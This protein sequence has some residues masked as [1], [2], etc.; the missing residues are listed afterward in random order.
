MAGFKSSVT[1]RINIFRDTPG[2]PV[3]QR[4]YYDHIIRN[5]REMSHI[6][7]YIETNPMRWADDKENLC[8][9]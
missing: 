1:K 8:N 7:D 3:W 6:W 9:W 2:V 5:N 4:N